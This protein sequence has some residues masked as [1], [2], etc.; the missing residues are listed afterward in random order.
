MAFVED[1]SVYFADLGVPVIFDAQETVGLLD[2]PSVDFDVSGLPVRDREYVLTM[3]AEGLDV[4]PKV[5]TV[6]EV[7]GVRYFAKTPP[8]YGTDAKLMKVRVKKA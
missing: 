4:V 2:E 5:G 8:D 3:R 6:I 1:M 7:G